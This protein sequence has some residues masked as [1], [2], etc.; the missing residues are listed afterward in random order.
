MMGWVDA[1]W[2]I[3]DAAALVLLSL[4]L[5]LLIKSAEAGQTWQVQ[6]QENSDPPSN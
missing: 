2:S 6:I 4:S 5:L 1:I 3:S